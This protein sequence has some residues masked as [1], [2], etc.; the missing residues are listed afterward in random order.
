MYNI[1]IIT[2]NPDT[3]DSIDMRLDWNEI[4]YNWGVC[5]VSIL[6]GFMTYPFAQPGEER[7]LA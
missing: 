1:K 3:I 5:V 2:P 6:M 7:R 4:L